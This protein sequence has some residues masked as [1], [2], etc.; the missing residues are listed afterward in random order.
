M[1]R[2]IFKS[3]EL[4]AQI[5]VFGYVKI[6]FLS[7][8]ELQACR[9][10]FNSL[11]PKLKVP[12][13]SSIDSKDINYRREVDRQLHELLGAKVEALFDNYKT[14][15]HTYIVKLPSP[16]TKIHLHLDDIHLDQRLFR[17]VNV[18]LPLVDV[19]RNNGCLR[20]YNGTHLLPK[21]HRGF[22]VDFIYR[23][24]IP[25]LEEGLLDVPVKAGELVV[26]DDLLIHASWPN[27]SDKIRPVIVSGLVPEEADLWACFHHKGLSDDEVEYYKVD[28]AFWL[29]FDKL[30]KPEEIYESLGVY[31][32]TK[33]E[34]SESQFRQKLSNLQQ[35]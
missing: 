15:A 23:P 4:E 18:W 31:K 20:V 17:A 8:A 21:Y 19:D 13:Y 34:F 27:L 9:E 24:Y 33:P 26:Y 35:K 6:P 28:K 30:D 29:S 22:G 3:D 11:D 25:V 5:S 16:D 1:K 14:I 2:R 10:I 12:F 7:E 32:V